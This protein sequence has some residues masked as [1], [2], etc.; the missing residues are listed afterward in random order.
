MLYVVLSGLVLDLIHKVI[1]TDKSK[2]ERIDI[3]GLIVD[4]IP[5]DFIAS[6][7]LWIFILVALL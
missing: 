7:Q 2:E 4:I 1:Y 3:I 6:G 5:K